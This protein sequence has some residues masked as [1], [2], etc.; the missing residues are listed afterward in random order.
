[1]K[2]KVPQR[3]GQEW[4]AYTEKGLRQ[5]IF[6]PYTGSSSNSEKTIMKYALFLFALALGLNV[7]AALRPV[8][9]VEPR[10]DT[11]NSRWIYFSS[12]CRPFGMVNLSPDTALENDWGSG[13]LYDEPFIRCFSHI[14]AWQL[15]GIPVLPIR[16][17]V[18][19]KDLT[20]ANKASF[21]HDDEVVKPGYHKVYLSDRAMTAELTSTT[22]VGFHRYTDAS[23][24]LMDLNRSMGKENKILACSLKQCSPTEFEGFVVMGPTTRRAKPFTAYF[25]AQLNRATAL[26]TVAGEVRDAITN[27]PLLLVA[28]SAKT[29]LLLKVALS[30]TSLAAARNNMTTE[31]PG[32]DFDG[33][34]RAA[35]DDWNTWLS[36]I[37]VEGGRHDQRV[38][39]YT[40]LWHALL[41]RRIVSDVD[42]AY[43]DNTGS[44]P[45]V[46]FCKRGPDG[47]PLHTHHNSDALWGSQWSIQ[48]LWGLAYPE[49]MSSFCN[50]YID[51]YK[52][53]GL[54]PRGPAGGDYTFVMVG[55]QACNFITSAYAQG[56]RDFDIDAAYAG[57]RKNAF[58][59]GI[60]D[61]AGYETGPNPAGGGMRFYEKLHYVPLHS[62]GKNW[63]REGAGQTMEYTFQDWCLSQFATALGKTD[64]AKLFAARSLGWTNLF[65]ATTGYIRPR[66][67]DGSWYKKFEPVTKGFSARGFVEGN[68]A[69][70][71]WFTPHAY[72]T[73]A[74]LMGGKAIAAK[75]LNEQFQRA[76]DRR[77]NAN[78]KTH[79][80]P[81][82]DY[83]NQPGTELAYVFNHLGMPWLTQYWA[84]QVKEMTF[85]G[86]TPW[87][88]YN[89]D[90]DQGQMGAVSA[91]LALGLFDIEGGSRQTPRYEL[92]APIFD[93]ITIHLSPTYYSGKTFVIT[94]T[95]N[96]VEHPYIQTATLNGQPLTRCWFNQSE[97]KKGGTLAL[98]VGA[99]PNLYWGVEK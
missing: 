53:G 82:I 56:I 97:L 1:M 52:N 10:I 66:E 72:D 7:C 83:G 79:A 50:T 62:E 93:K 3:K 2:K 35:L 94:V 28:E 6:I 22:R 91:M 96:R 99:E 75:R 13:Y 14:H 19:D 67:L 5:G 39:F 61:R 51:M 73:L 23:T 33:T 36:R 48:N 68:S 92:S 77:Y 89:D 64:D 32:W 30:Y 20:E 18:V 46:R 12:A 25:I 84:R 58:V 21:S 40:D 78:G 90:E 80:D 24:L 60:R 43:L 8:D 4:I 42:G 29:P 44:S 95:N 81:W 69:N 9:Y 31:L 15:F 37:E 71:T 70:Y 38:K 54:I 85:G 55:D 41:G 34:T 11:K 59:G 16:Q 86:T 76:R 17:L 57:L 26:K 47:K 88:G 27:A 98:T 49:V 74:Q 45:A 65:D 87:S 63:H